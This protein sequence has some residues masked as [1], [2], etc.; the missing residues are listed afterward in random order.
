VQAG[1]VIV[2]VWGAFHRDEKCDLQVMDGNVIQRQY[3]RAMGT[4]ML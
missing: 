2:T 3:I 4:K 1:G